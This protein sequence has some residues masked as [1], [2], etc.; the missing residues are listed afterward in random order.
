MHE[1]GVGVSTGQRHDHGVDDEVCGLA[2]AHRPA[3][4]ALVV[5]V[6]DAGQEPLAVTAAELGDVGHPPLVRARCGE[7]AVQKNGSWCGVGSAS[8]PLLALVGADETA[9]GHDPGHPLG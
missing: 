8:P 6:F 2:F 9:F 1:I 5:E 3:G 7:V 4:Q